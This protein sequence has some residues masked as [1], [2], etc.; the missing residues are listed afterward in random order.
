MS[1]TAPFA[2]TGDTQGPACPSKVWQLDQLTA[3]CLPRHP[4]QTFPFRLLPSLHCSQILSACATPCPTWS[5][6]EAGS[7]A[8]G[9]TCIPCLLLP[10]WTWAS[11]GPWA[12][13]VPL[14]TDILPERLSSPKIL[15]IT[16][17]VSTQKPG[18]GSRSHFSLSFLVHY[19]FFEA[20]DAPCCVCWNRKG[21]R[22][23]KKFKIQR[24]KPQLTF[25][26]FI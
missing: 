11:S 6:T 14:T 23:K 17:R 25:Q 16:S 15:P 2:H 1:F 24:K 26:S 4:R 10:A 8:L 3:S 13:G 21:P 12:P 20:K 22:G 18:K 5:G 9:H 7:T 19:P